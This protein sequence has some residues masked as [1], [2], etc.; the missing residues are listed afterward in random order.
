MPTPNSTTPPVRTTTQRPWGRS[1]AALALGAGLLA[2]VAVQ[3]VPEQAAA[4]PAAAASAP[5]APAEKK[6]KADDGFRIATL[7]LH[8]N[9]SAGQLRGDVRKMIKQRQP[10]IIG[11]QER[12]DT[13]RQM[14]AALPDHWALRMPVKRDGTDD[15]PIA[16]DKRVWKAKSSWPRLLTGRTWARNSGQTAVDQYGVVTVLEHRRTGQVVRAISFHMPNLI[17]NRNTGGPNYG[18]PQRLGAFYRMAASVRELARRTP[19]EQQFVALCDCNVTESKDTTGK[20]VK[21][22]LTRPLGLENQYSAAGYKS[23]WRIDYVMS[24]KDAAYRIDGWHVMHRLHTDHPGVVTQFRP[25][26]ELKARSYPRR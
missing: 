4:A 13:R 17:H 7:N 12:R 1:I 16:F 11:F 20:L 21:G 18:E 10:S 6:R 15:N 24:E 14:R 23:G 25:A 9:L 26:P 22:K 3:A 2:P 19:E 8:N 5:V